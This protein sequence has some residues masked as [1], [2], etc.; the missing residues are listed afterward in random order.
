MAALNE[1]R[2]AD[3]LN[4]LLPTHPQYASLKSALQITPRTEVDKLN[5]IRLNMD[6]WRWLPR[7]LGQKYIIVNVPS[8]YATLVENGATRWKTR[9]VAGASQDSDS[10]TYGD[11]SRR[12]PQLEVGSTQEHL[13]RGGWQARLCCG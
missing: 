10:A 11:R 8:Y 1:N 2:L 13:A 12:D 5:K 6:R 7:D 4:G 3:A 9:A